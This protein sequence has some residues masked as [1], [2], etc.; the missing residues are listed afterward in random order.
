MQTIK[1]VYTRD[2][3]LLD[4]NNII[5]T[6][7]M[8][9][10]NARN[11]FNQGM[12]G[13]EM[14]FYQVVYDSYFPP[15]DDDSDLTLGTPFEENP[16]K[17]YLEHCLVSASRLKQCLPDKKILF[18]NDNGFYPLPLDGEGFSEIPENFDISSVILFS[19]KKRLKVMFDHEATGIWDY[20]GKSI[21]LEYVP[22]SDTT[23]NLIATFQQGLNSMEIAYDREYTWEE[24]KQYA[25]HMV[26]G[27]VAAMALKA[28]L[29]DWQILLYNP[30]CYFALPLNPYNNC[31]EI[32]SDLRLDD[33]LI[34][35]LKLS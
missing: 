17:V 22:V 28:E 1:V 13:Y 8:L 9:P 35:S 3:V 19:G 32:M 7:D 20:E 6:Y 15:D 29:P 14:D 11:I 31:S 30:E 18:R 33:V 16:E 23:R 34:T 2:A 10:E 25:G 26:T 5:I 27:L 12:N 4:E 24:E 21:P